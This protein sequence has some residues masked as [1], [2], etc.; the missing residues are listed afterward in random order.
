VGVAAS[1]R[2]FR[3]AAPWRT[4][5]HALNLVG[6]H[7]TARIATMLGDPALVTVAMGLLVSM[8]GIP[9]LWAGDE[10]GQVGTNGEEG[11]RTFPWDDRDQW[12]NQR[13]SSTK[14][15]LAARRESTALR[16]GGL[17]W[18]AIS[19]NAFTFLRE[20]PDETVLVHASRTNHSPVRLPARVAGTQLTGLAGT[21]DLRADADGHVSL[22]T[23]GPAFSMWRVN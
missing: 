16:H 17:R 5:A 12:D 20:A 2:D 9:M 18:L 13:L 3:A 11:R 14:S 6:S 1:M 15:L 10:I 23:D 19:D 4:T 22:P 8:P 7:D 21:A